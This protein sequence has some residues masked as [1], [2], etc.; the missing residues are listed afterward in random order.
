MNEYP[1]A[2]G[3]DA[4]DI[5]ERPVV[6]APDYR[7]ACIEARKT[8]GRAWT[9]VVVSDPLTGAQLNVAVKRTHGNLTAEEWV[10]RAL[11]DP[12]D[13]PIVSI[14]AFLAALQPNIVNFPGTTHDRP[15]W[16]LLNGM[17]YAPA[18]IGIDP[19][20]GAIIIAP[21]PEPSGTYTPELGQ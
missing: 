1:A 12:V 7:T 3:W 8:L 14:D 17:V 10:T 13:V 4:N 15:V 16:I 20:H 5:I 2:C 19:K 18:Q 11:A 9:H 21:A 6:R